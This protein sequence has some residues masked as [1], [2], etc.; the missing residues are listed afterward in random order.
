MCVIQT[1]SG[2]RSILL[3]LHF[4]T[5]LI[6]LDLESRSQEC[7]KAKTFAPIISQSFQSMWM[8]FGILLRLAG[9]MDL[10]HI[11]VGL[12]TIQRREPYFSTY[13]FLLSI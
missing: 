9:V 11:L 10:I 5:S 2:D 8:E 3:N 13:V 1:W 7:R 12:F 6:N 4:D